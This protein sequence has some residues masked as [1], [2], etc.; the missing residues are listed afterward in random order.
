MDPDWG[1][2]SGPISRNLTPNTA[3]HF[4]PTEQTLLSFARKS[5]YRLSPNLISDSKSLLGVRFQGEILENS[6]VFCV[7]NYLFLK[8]N[9]KTPLRQKQTN[10]KE[11]KKP[12]TR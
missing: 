1:G 12:Q 3:G 10:K 6:R 8:T 4:I 5:T 2:G 11:N 7:R 9:G